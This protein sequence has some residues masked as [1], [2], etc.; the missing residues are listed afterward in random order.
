MLRSHLRPFAPSR[1][2]CGSFRLCAGPQGLFVFGRFILR[3]GN[4]LLRLAGAA[5]VKTPYDRFCQVE[6]PNSATLSGSKAEPDLRRAHCIMSNPPKSI[7]GQTRR[8]WVA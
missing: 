4:R 7:I 3:A 1:Y 2:L 8:W 6:D 5:G